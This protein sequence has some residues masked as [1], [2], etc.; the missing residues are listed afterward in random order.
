MVAAPK[1]QPKVL[2]CSVPS[3]QHRELLRWQLHPTDSLQSLAVGIWGF[4]IPPHT[5]CCMR[6]PHRRVLPTAGLLH[7]P[8]AQMPPRSTALLSS[9]GLSTSPAIREAFLSSF[10]LP[11]FK[12]SPCM[13]PDDLGI[14]LLWGWQCRGAPA[15]AASRQKSPRKLGLSS[16]GSGQGRQAA[17]TLVPCRVRQPLALGPPEKGK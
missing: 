4:E 5:L 13:N 7:S 17:E 14:R 6:P 16:A 9:E 15:T 2:G 1:Q 8:W 11:R 12:F 3:R 10:S